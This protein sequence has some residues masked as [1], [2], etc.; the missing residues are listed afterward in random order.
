MLGVEAVIREGVRRLVLKRSRRM[1]FDFISML[2]RDRNR[3]IEQ[4]RHTTL[5]DNGWPE[6]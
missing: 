2:G 1:N 3:V 5:E 4:Y 6:E